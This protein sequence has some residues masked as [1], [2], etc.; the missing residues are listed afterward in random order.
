[1]NRMLTFALHRKNYED[2]YSFYRERRPKITWKIIFQGFLCGL[3]GESLGHHLYMKSM[4]LTSATFITAM[5]N[6]IPA[7]TFVIGIIARTAVGKTKVF[8]TLMGIGGAMLLTFYKDFSIDFLKS[9]INLLY[10]ERTCMS[11]FWYTNFSIQAKMSETFP[12]HYASTGLMSLMAFFQSTIYALCVERDWTQWKLGW[13]IRLWTGTMGPA[14]VVA[15]M[16]IC[17]RL[18]GPLFVAVFNPLLLVIHNEM[19]KKLNGLVP[20]EENEVQKSVRT[21]VVSGNNSSGSIEMK[22]MEN[23]TSGRKEVAM[24]SCH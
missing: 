3:F 17:A 20:L 2:I 21:I 13:D 19:K 10:N 6:L 16:S 7:V 23:S 5:E 1:M 15:L 9:D 14:L 8:R 12:C 18:R 11:C 22:M 24:A 4:A